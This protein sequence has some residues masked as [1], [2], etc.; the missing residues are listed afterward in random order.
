MK[1]CRKRITIK[2][3]P[4]PKA[5][6]VTVSG[7]DPFRRVY[8]CYAPVCIRTEVFAHLIV[9]AYITGRENDTVFGQILC[10]AFGPFYD[11]A[12]YLS[13][14]IL[15]KLLSRTV[16]HIFNAQFN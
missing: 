1:H 7:I 9:A 15:Y 8:T 14:R 6:P 2:E 5:H 13:V 4:C 11:D 16:E 12:F 10:I 3:S